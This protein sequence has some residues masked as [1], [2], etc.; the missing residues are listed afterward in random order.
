MKSKKVIYQ[1]YIRPT[2][3]DV[4]ILKNFFEYLSIIICIEIYMQV[5]INAYTHM[6][7]VYTCLYN[8]IYIFTY[9]L[10]VYFSVNH[11]S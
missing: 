6:C 1:K 4:S 9:T 8:I 10:G 7:N 2:L 3:L 5:C 11:L